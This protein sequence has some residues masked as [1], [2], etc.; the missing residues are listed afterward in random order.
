MDWNLMNDE[1]FGSI[2]L[3]KLKYRR[4]DLIIYLF[5]IIGFSQEIKLSQLIQL[6]CKIGFPAHLW[7]LGTVFNLREFQKTG[8]N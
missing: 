4:G 5:F 7:K 2:E 1:E 8:E 6:F 3:L